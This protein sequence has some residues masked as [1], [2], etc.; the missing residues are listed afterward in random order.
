MPPIYGDASAALIT[1]YERQVRQLEEQRIILEEKI[2][3]CGRVDDSFYEINRTATLSLPFLVLR[4]FSEQ[5]SGMVE[6][7]GVEP[8]TSTMPS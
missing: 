5:K 2:R 8:L 3:N 1:A 7:S 6:H 4:E